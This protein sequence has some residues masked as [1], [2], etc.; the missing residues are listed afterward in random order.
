[1]QTLSH[2][3]PFERRALRWFRCRVADILMGVA[4]DI[5]A[6]T[7]EPLNGTEPYF[8]DLLD[9][10]CAR[11]RRYVYWTAAVHYQGRGFATGHW[12]VYSGEIEIDFERAQ[13]EATRVHAARELADVASLDQWLAAD[14]A[15]SLPAAPLGGSHELP[16]QARAALTTLKQERELRARLRKTCPQCGGRW[17]VRSGLE[18][19]HDL[20]AKRCP[21]CREAKSRKR[22]A[23]QEAK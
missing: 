6:G 18:F 5:P 7:R 17:S 1:M 15:G 13:A 19:P 16:E 11:S 4:I 10:Y 9:W 14:L 3:P 23:A 12:S 22:P 8:A 20:N 21:S 2:E